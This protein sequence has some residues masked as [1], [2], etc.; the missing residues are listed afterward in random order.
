METVDP[1]NKVFIVVL[2][3]I[4]IQH[5]V[6]VLVIIVRLTVPTYSIPHAQKADEIKLL[7]LKLQ[8]TCAQ[9]ANQCQREQTL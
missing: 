1:V 2:W 4:K 3:A 6:L 8:I 9:F 7:E 5:I